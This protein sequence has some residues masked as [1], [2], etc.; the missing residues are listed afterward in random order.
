MAQAAFDGKFLLPFAPERPEFFLVPGNN[1]VT[2]LWAASATETLPDPF[3]QVAS[4]PTTAPNP[5][6]L[7]DPNFRGND[8]EGYRIYRG[9]ND[10]NPHRAADDRA[11]RLC[12]DRSTGRPSSRTSVPWS[13]RMSTCAPELGV[14]LDCAGIVYSTPAPGSPFV[15]NADIDIVGTIT[16]VNPGNRV[17]LADGKAQILPDTLDTAFA[18]VSKGR[19]AQ[20]VSTT[21]ANTGVPFIFIDRMFGSA[22]QTSTRWSRSTSQPAGLGFSPASSPTCTSPAAGA[23]GELPADLDQPGDPCDW[24]Q[25]SHADRLQD[26]AI[27]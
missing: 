17:L 7:Y 15:G 23:V 11:I 21:L 1:Q 2:V 25:G 6:P 8:V 18:D 10:K 14:T 26:G 13:I 20:G 3:F 9:R 27:D 12:A 24:W 22:V 16:Q 19:I 4:E 5:N